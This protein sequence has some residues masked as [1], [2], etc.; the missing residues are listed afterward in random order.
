[1]DDLVVLTADITMKGV[2]TTLLNYPNFLGIR[3]IS[4]EVLAHINRDPGV[5]NNGHD[6]LRER[7]LRSHQYSILIF[8]KSGCGQERKPTHEIT[9]IV[10]NNLDNNGW[11][12][13]SKVIVIDPELEAWFWNNS[14]SVANVL[15]Y[16]PEE[17]MQWLQNKGYS[18]IS[19]VKYNH[20]KE[21]VESALK[22]KRKPFSSSIHRDLT[23]KICV[24]GLDL[25]NCQD[26]AFYE[27]K[28]TLREWFPIT[29]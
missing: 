6:L 19:Q 28:N 13:R 24:N 3:N 14:P 7:Y 12:D 26:H 1:M 16:E 8:D 29:D 17:L 20:P 27:F 11:I 4:K 21:M 2:I 15:G 23:E 25:D 22:N 9:N 10:Q 5:F 18:S